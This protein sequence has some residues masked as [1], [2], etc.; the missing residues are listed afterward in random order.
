[1]YDRKSY[2]ETEIGFGQSL[3]ILMIDFQLGF[4]DFTRI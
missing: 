3:A 2:G 1:M 4:T